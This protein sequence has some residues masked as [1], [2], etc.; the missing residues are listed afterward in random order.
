MLWKVR[1]YQ[2]CCLW[3][4]P[5]LGIVIESPEKKKSRENKG[6]EAIQ[7]AMKWALEL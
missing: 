6:C 5:K 3:E 7:E 4:A 1:K 2:A